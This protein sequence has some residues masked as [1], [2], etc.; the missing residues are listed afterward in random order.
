MGW[1]ALIFV[2]PC[3][4]L[5]PLHT[6]NPSLLTQRKLTSTASPGRPPPYTPG[7]Q[8]SCAT[9]G[10]QIS[11]ETRR[12]CTRA[13][14]VSMYSLVGWRERWTGPRGAEEGRTDRASTGFCATTEPAAS[15][16]GRCETGPV[17]E[18]EAAGRRARWVPG[19]GLGRGLGRDFF[20]PT[21]GASRRHLGCRVNLDLAARAVQR[22]GG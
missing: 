17:R 10:P 7:P 14:L 8:I 1:V 5:S 12:R 13:S 19:W 21:P 9:T 22:G 6:R 15:A 20:P 3:L 18:A 11:C 16:A 4:S 2:P